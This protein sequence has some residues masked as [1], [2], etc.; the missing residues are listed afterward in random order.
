MSAYARLSLTLQSKEAV[1]LASGWWAV[2]SNFSAC[3]H[4]VWLQGCPDWQEA[5]SPDFQHSNNT[6][7][8]HHHCQGPHSCTFDNG[9]ESGAVHSSITVFPH[10]HETWWLQNIVSR[11]STILPLPRRLPV[12]LIIASDKLFDH[13]FQFA[14]SRQSWCSLH[15]PLPSPTAWQTAILMRLTSKEEGSAESK[16]RKFRREKKIQNSGSGL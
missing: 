1:E 5:R 4:W 6:D 13:V 8:R 16:I 12:Q 10:V 7:R 9:I 11:G 15:L 14:D 3:F 2:Q